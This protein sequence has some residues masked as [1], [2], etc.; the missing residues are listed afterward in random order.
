MPADRRRL[1][2]FHSSI[3]GFQLTP[4]YTAHFKRVFVDG[5]STFTASRI[6]MLMMAL[7]FAL[8]DLIPQEIEFI[9]Q[10]I[11]TR[12]VD[13]VD[14]RMPEPPE[15]P[16]PDIVNCL[17]C[18]LDWYMMARLLLFPMD[19]TPELQRRAFVMKGEL[20]RVFPEKT[21][22]VAAWNFPKMHST[23]KT[24]PQIMTFATTPFTDTNTF[25]A[26]HRPNIK[27]Y[28][29]NSNGKDQYKIIAGHHDRV[30]SLTTLKKCVSRHAKF[31]SRGKE[32]DSESSSQGDDDDDDDICTDPLTS[33]PCEMA[34][35]LPLL[36]MTYD[37]KALRREPLSL[38]LKGS[39][40][41]RIVLAACKPGAPAPSNRGKASG[42]K[43]LYN[44]AVEFPNLKFLPAQLAHFA[45]EYLR[46]SLGLEDLPEAERDING[47]LDNCL[48][49]DSDGADIF[50]FGGMAIRSQHHKGTVRMRARP[51]AS[52]KF[53]G[54]NPQVYTR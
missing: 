28:S 47:V 32:S 33:R 52:D 29:G 19:D 1:Q 11:R 38:G 4:K 20:Q 45:Y 22:E 3:A 10:A 40:R 8:R 7:P 51:F 49:R 39:G 27:A 25:E 12:Q 54:R 50:T 34:A 21:G 26:A 16:C 18:F 6:E 15:D 9:K 14:G 5:K 37:I 48:L 13:A 53:F 24:G 43:F 35:R 17:A 36:E 23:E 46:S 2:E 42:T 30:A 41:Q 31:L 44:H